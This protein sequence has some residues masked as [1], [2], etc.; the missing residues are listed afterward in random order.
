MTADSN[1]PAPYMLSVQRLVDITGLS[2][3]TLG[4]IATIKY[5]ELRELDDG[6]EQ[7]AERLNALPVAELKGLSASP[8]PK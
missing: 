3:R 5:P 7:A 6:A 1:P 8:H 4:A 2:P